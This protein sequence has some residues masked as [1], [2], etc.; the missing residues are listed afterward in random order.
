[1]VWFGYC[2]SPSHTELGV[3]Y[4]AF[5]R[6]LTQK[7]DIA[8]IGTGYTTLGF[9][10]RAAA[11]TWCERN[12][13]FS[14]PVTRAS[15]FLDGPEVVAAQADLERLVV[16]WYIYSAS[17]NV[18][19]T[20]AVGYNAWRRGTAR[21]RLGKQGASTVRRLSSIMVSLHAHTTNHPGESGRLVARR[22]CT[23]GV[24]C[25]GSKGRR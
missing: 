15:A 21:R 12:E 25:L 11:Q 20:W 1:M 24:R 5:W 3:G 10:F 16:V 23:W 4:P 17:N 7:G 6:W 13:M 8:T 18:G 2:G 9:N 14:A 22:S 19:G